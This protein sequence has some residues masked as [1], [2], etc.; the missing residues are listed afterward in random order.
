MHARTTLRRIVFALCAV[1]AFFLSLEGGLWAVGLASRWALRRRLPAAAE[2]AVPTL[3]CVGD[4]VTFGLGADTDRAYPAVLGTLRPGERVVNLGQPGFST[5]RAAGVLEGWLASAGPRGTTRIVLLTGFNDCAHLPGLLA[6]SSVEARPVRDLL[7]RTRTYRALTQM[8]RRVGP[9]P[10]RADG[11]VPADPAGDLARCR[12]AIAAGLDRVEALCDGAGVA[13]TL[14][15]Y[16]VPARFSSDPARVTA[17]VDGILA[18]E[19]AARG[20]P[21]LDLRACMEAREASGSPAFYNTD[22]LHLSA[23]GYAAMG[24]CVAAALPAR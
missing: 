15:T 20:L 24:A 11:P 14:L 13:L 16:P 18:R 8:L 4:S 7:R 9:T 6:A 21:L 12:G 23:E 19:A 3:A 1:V 17:Q 5:D 2:D 22:G 10:R